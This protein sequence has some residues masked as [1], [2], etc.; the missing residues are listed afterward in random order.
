M[1]SEG[2]PYEVDD[3]DADTLLVLARDA[4]TRVRA[5]ERT[6]LNLAARWCVLQPAKT[7]TGDPTGHATWSEA[8]GPDLLG[9]DEAIGGDGTPLVAAFAA[10]PFA[11]ALGISTR[12][13]LQLMAD[14]LNLEH[15]QPGTWRR[16]QSLNIAPW[17]ARRLAQA[18]ASLSLAAA[19]QVDAVLVERIDSCGTLTIERAVA[20][21]RARFDPETVAVAEDRARA[22]WGVDLHHGGPGDWAATSWIDA[23]GDTTD[24][25]RFHDLVCETAEALKRGG[26]EDALD[27]RKAKALGVIADQLT[28]P[29]TPSGPPA[30]AGDPRWSSSSRPTTTMRRRRD[31]TCYVHLDWAQLDA[32]LTDTDRGAAGV[33]VVERLGPTTVARIGDWLTGSRHVRIQPV[34]D[35]GRVDAVDQHDPPTWMQEL[36]RLRDPHCVFPWCETGSRSCDL[37]HIAPYDPGTPQDPGPPAQTRPENLAPLCR[38]H[39]RCKTAGRWRYQRN[40]DGSY[41]WT[42]PHHRRYLVTPLGTHELR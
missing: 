11:A 2:F 10:E 20:E 12:A 6:K 24:L 32:A 4:E 13:G 42:S 31:W 18:T 3:L 19:R 33:G 28:N 7:D 40:T 17:R 1:D 35:L 39:H 23:V 29:D 14:A 27:L 41:T 25:T 34:L 8:G 21:A 5:A 30:P 15:R 26:D 16:V 38:R 9:C 37:D 36:V 22:A